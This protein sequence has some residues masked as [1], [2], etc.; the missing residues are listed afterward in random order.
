MWQKTPVS[1]SSHV[2]T[3][4]SY[5]ELKLYQWNLYMVSFCQTIWYH[6]A[7]V[8]LPTGAHTDSQEQSQTASGETNST[9]DLET[10]EEIYSVFKED[11]R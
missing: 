6:K 11:G 3:A 2:Q 1:N 9:K 5:S 7:K 4:P 10:K 8:T